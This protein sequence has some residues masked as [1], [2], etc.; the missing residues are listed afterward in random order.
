VARTDSCLR[1]GAYLATICVHSLRFRFA[2]DHAHAL[3]REGH[4]CMKR[5]L[6]A[7]RASV[8]SEA[9]RRASSAMRHTLAC[10]STLHST[11][12]HAPIVRFIAHSLICS[13]VCRL[14]SIH[15][16]DARIMPRSPPQLFAR[17]P[18]HCDCDHT[19]YTSRI[20]PDINRGS[21]GCSSTPRVTIL[22][23]ST[24]ARSSTAAVHLSTS[25]EWRAPHLVSS[26]ALL[27]SDGL[28]S[29]RVHL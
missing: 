13:L 7:Y 16:F 22:C 28:L 9:A 11:R 12:L 17:R 8:G 14:D 23:K 18:P 15:A 29:S 21:V 4:E 26:S 19:S 10:E 5:E 27:S 6:D 24:H 25:F 3:M 2:D 1:L 20:R